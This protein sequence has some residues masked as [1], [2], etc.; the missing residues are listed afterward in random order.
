MTNRCEAS[1]EASS[2]EM[3][4]GDDMKGLEQQYESVSLQEHNIPA[5]PKKTTP[6]EIPQLNEPLEDKRQENSEKRERD[7][8]HVLSDSP[9][10]RRR[11]QRRNSVTSKMISMTAL[12]LPDIDLEE[13]GR[14][15]P[16]FDDDIHIAVNLVQ[17]FQAS[18]ERHC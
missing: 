9:S 12:S 11:F 2:S 8:S 17:H 1:H 5:R 15:C 10:K 3:N 4:K 6:F 16:E 7:L 18:H 13:G 14:A